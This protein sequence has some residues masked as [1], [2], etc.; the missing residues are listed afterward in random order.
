MTDVSKKI[1]LPQT[2][3]AGGNK[4]TRLGPSKTQTVRLKHAVKIKLRR[5]LRLDCQGRIEVCN[6]LIDNI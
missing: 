4:T 5:L 1:T 3:F 6:F 2:S